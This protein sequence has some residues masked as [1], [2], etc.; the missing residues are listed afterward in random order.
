MIY[1]GLTGAFVDVFVE[2]GSGGLDGPS[3]GQFLDGRFV[4]VSARSDS[5]LEYD[6]ETGRFE[7]VLV[8]FRSGGLQYPHFMQVDGGVLYLAGQ[9]R[10]NILKYDVHTGDFLGELVAPGSG[11][12]NG[13]RGLLILPAGLNSFDADR[14][15]DVDVKDYGAF[16]Q[17][18]TGPRR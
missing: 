12:L 8:S 9:R 5:V 6:Q 2:A 13:P 7:G 1:D 16:Q 10:S 15:G 11:G 17:A 18:F 3:D 14:D 4:L